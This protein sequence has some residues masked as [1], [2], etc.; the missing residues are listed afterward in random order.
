MCLDWHPTQPDVILSG[1][2]DNT[3]KVWNIKQLTQN[4]RFGMKPLYQVQTQNSVKK[5]EWNQDKELM[6]T[7]ISTEK[8][9]N[10]VSVWHLKKPYLQ[11]YILKGSAGLGYSDF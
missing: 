1:G 3:I 5:S 2:Q 7:S 10:R 6:I 11:Q 9:E 4:G 8:T